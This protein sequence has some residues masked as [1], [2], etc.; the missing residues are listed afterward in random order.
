MHVSSSVNQQTIL[1]YNDFQ[2]IPE[3]LKVSAV[4]TFTSKE[5]YGNHFD[6]H[7]KKYVNQGNFKQVIYLQTMQTNLS[8]LQIKRQ[9]EVFTFL[10]SNKIQ[11]LVHE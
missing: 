7:F 9:L 11:I 6:I 2:P 10:K 4:M 5:T 3:I 8:L 1:E